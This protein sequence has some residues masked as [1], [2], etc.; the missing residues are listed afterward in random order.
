MGLGS[1]ATKLLVLR[2]RVAFGLCSAKK[3]DFAGGTSSYFEM[4]MLCG[5]GFCAFCSAARM[6][7][8]R[9]KAPRNAATQRVCL[10]VMCDLLD[11][12]HYPSVH[13]IPPPL[14]RCFWVCLA[15]SYLNKRPIACLMQYVIS[16]LADT[17]SAVRP[18]R[19]SNVLMAISQ[20]GLSLALAVGFCGSRTK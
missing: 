13:T 11:Q 3:M 10:I 16:E 7:T 19:C 4:F 6:G 1:T 9:G 18:L 8:D 5:A 20:R 17:V 2:W 12:L 15:A 14:Q